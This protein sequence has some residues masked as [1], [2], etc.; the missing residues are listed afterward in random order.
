MTA[1]Q[2]E[3]LWLNGYIRQMI[4]E[5]DGVPGAAQGVFERK[6]QTNGNGKVNGH[7]NGHVNGGSDVEKASVGGQRSGPGSRALSGEMGGDTN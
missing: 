7:T 5:R 1:K 4:E 6:G 3:G 2:L